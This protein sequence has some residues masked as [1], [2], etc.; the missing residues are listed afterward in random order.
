MAVGIQ[1]KNRLKRFRQS[2]RQSFEQEEQDVPVV[3][4]GVTVSSMPWLDLCLRSVRIMMELVSKVI[5]TLIYR[6][7]PHSQLPPIKNLVLL[8]S[9]SSLALKIRQKKLTSEEVVR[10]F[11][12][13]IKEI[14]PILN[15]VVDERF[16]E[17][18]KEAKEVD[19]GIRNGLLTEKEMEERK[20]FLGVPFSI[21]D[22]FMVKG[23]HH[24]A[25][26]WIRKDFVAEADADVVQLMRKAGA[27]PLCVTNVSELCM[28]WE[29][30]NKIYGRTSNP[31]C[32]YRIV[33][34]SS[35]GEACVQA[36]CGAPIGLGSDIGGSIRMP[37]FFNGVFGH[38]PTQGIV[39]NEG[40]EPVAVG[41]ALDF[42]VTGPIVKYAND[43][44]PVY[45]VLAANNAHMVN[46]NKKASISQV[47]LFY[48]EDDGGSAFTT[49][50]HSELRNA[51]KRILVH[52][53]KGYGIKAVKVKLS[54]FKAAVPIYFA[55]L[56][57]V[58]GAHTFCEEL[59]LKKGCIN[60]WWEVMK[61]SLRLS[62]HTMPALLLGIFEKFFT[63]SKTTEEYPKLL[64]MCSDLKSELKELLGEDG[65]LL[66]PSHPTP[67]P[68]HS[69]PLFRTFNFAYTAI[70]NVLG[71]PVTQ[72]P[73]G[74]GSDGVPLGIQV[75]ANHHQDHLTLAVAVELEK[76]FGGWVCPSQVL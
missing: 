23:L 73:M 10:S 54:K 57:S 6:G 15:C 11:I 46:I 66:Y 61:W 22:S 25:G 42:L 51:Q 67:A 3:E 48:M 4:T 7:N 68:Y 43:L 29:S 60:V 63:Y 28:W 20:P 52:F 37:C 59:A 65:V 70:F 62:K 5:F 50:V 8:E 27:I 69:Q 14:N 56:A 36:A 41:E 13:R 26:L 72:C 16:E 75:V 24:T 47:R 38:K 35:G 74:L 34:G 45:R 58:E 49:P 53:E 33:G 32:T 76:A 12:E 39:S 18:L 44:I 55:K 17:A 1:I 30:A 71:L 31:Y 9:G 40:Q 21:K 2:M 19:K 64:T